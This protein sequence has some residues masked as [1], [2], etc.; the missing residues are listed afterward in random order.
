[1]TS[2]FYEKYKTLFEQNEVRLTEMSTGQQQRTS[3]NL[4][5]KLY[6]STPIALPDSKPFRAPDPRIE[7]DFERESSSKIQNGLR[8]L[9]RNRR[10]KDYGDNTGYRASDS[11]GADRRQNALP[12]VG[13]TKGIFANYAREN[14]QKFMER[15]YE[16]KKSAHLERNSGGIR[17]DENQGMVNGY[18]TQGQLTYGKSSNAGKNKSLME[19]E[20]RRFSQVG[21]SIL[22]S[23]NHYGNVGRN[24]YRNQNQA[25]NYRTGQGLN[26]GRND[27]GNFDVAANHQNYDPNNFAKRVRFRGNNLKT[28]TGI[29]G[30]NNSRLSAPKHENHIGLNRQQRKS[31]FKP[32]NVKTGRV[33]FANNGR[34]GLEPKKSFL[35]KFSESSDQNLLP[36]REEKEGTLVPKQH[37]GYNI[38]SFRISKNLYGKETQGEL[39]SHYKS[40]FHRLRQGEDVDS[41]EGRKV[42]LNPNL[43]YLK[44][45]VVY[46]Q[47]NQLNMGD[48]KKGNGEEDKGMGDDA[49]SVKTGGG[50]GKGRGEAGKARFSLNLERYGMGAVQTPR[51]SKMQLRTEKVRAIEKRQIAQSDPVFL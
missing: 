44:D 35:N 22:N 40:Q 15:G 7:K 48:G 16:R 29:F 27:R 36:R 30:L 21:K 49:A 50:L 46:G 38:E 14:N 13:G 25:D 11:L 26:P 51:K 39:Q 23:G 3:A 43:E 5:Q 6:T 20:L 10:I 47:G 8:L 9:K 31:S 17:R 41:G 19:K 45:A 32:Q 2:R 33:L 28:N 12:N 1:M 34:Q 24:N 4:I 37:P 18:S 42:E